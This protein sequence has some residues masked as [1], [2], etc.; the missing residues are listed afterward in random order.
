MT[1]E[2][3]RTLATGCDQTLIAA[4]STEVRHRASKTQHRQAKTRLRWVV[5]SAFCAAALAVA[6]LLGTKAIVALAIIAPLALFAISIARVNGHEQAYKQAYVAQRVGE[7]I[8][9]PQATE[10]YDRQLLARIEAQNL[11]ARD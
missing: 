2:K 7:G 6:P 9:E 4:L 5:A 11:L 3:T 8:P 10:D 1:D